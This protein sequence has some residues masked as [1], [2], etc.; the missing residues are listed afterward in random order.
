MPWAPSYIT[1][2]ELADFVRTDQ[3]TE[4]D[5]LALAA[6]AASRAVD[7]ATNRQ[8]GKVAAAEQRFYVARY[9]YRRARWIVRMDDVQD[10]TGFAVEIDG[11]AVTGHFFGPINN[12]VKGRP[13]EEIILSNSAEATPSGCEPDVG[14]TASYGWSAVPGTVKEATLL[15]GSRFFERMKS[16]YGVA[17]SPDLGSEIRLLARADPDVAVML[18][19]YTRDRVTIG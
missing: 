3:V 14:I 5:R 2:T 6:E 9:N 17:G 12:A 4:E 15:Q 16:P 8:F 1:T 11:T 13:Y 10:V 18:R 7:D 19:D